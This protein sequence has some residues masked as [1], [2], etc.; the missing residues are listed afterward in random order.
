MWKFNGILT[1]YDS[2]ITS[3]STPAATL[4]TGDSANNLYDDV[5]D[6]AHDTVFVASQKGL[7]AFVAPQDGAG[8]TFTMQSG[9]R[10]TGLTLRADGAIFATEFT[11]GLVVSF[12]APFSAATA[13]VARNVDGDGAGQGIKFLP[14]GSLLRTNVFD[15]AFL[16]NAPVAG[17]SLLSV[18]SLSILD[19]SDT[20]DLRGF[21][22]GN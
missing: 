1:R 13:R 17:V 10:Y 16:Q 5:V 12:H 19:G 6:D 4:S 14:D 3:A 21:A 22:F 2:P 18:P 15:A 7:V 9:S 11:S 20:T 8:P